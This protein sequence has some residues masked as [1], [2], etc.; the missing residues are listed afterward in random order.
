MQARSP[1]GWWCSLPRSLSEEEDELS[2]SDL[3]SLCRKRPQNCIQLKDVDT[4]QTRGTTNVLADA[5]STG[6]SNWITITKREDECSTMLT[7]H[8][9]K[10]FF[11]FSF[12]CQLWL[13]ADCFRKR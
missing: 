13:K 11:A 7:E 2:A 1:V 12:F 10:L 9:P 4:R 8:V 5:K 6:K 3:F